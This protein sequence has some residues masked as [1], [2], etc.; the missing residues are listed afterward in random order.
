M[1]DLCVHSICVFWR[2]YSDRVNDLRDIESSNGNGT[3]KVSF[4]LDTAFWVP[5]WDKDHFNTQA[6]VG[7]FSKFEPELAFPE[8]NVEGGMLNWGLRSAEFSKNTDSRQHETQLG[9]NFETTIDGG[10]GGKAAKKSPN[11]KRVVSVVDS[12]SHWPRLWRVCISDEELKAMQKLDKKEQKKMIPSNED[13]MPKALQPRLRD[14]FTAMDT[15]REKNL[16]ASSFEGVA[17]VTY[18]ITCTHRNVFQLE[19]FPFD[20]HNL[21][22]V[23]RLDKKEGDPMARTIIPTAHDKGFFVSS[24][25]SEMVNFKLARNLDWEVTKEPMATG[26]LQR[27]NTYAIVRRNA[28]YYTRNYIIISFLLTSSVFSC[29][30]ARPE[31]MNARA[32]IVFTVVVSTIAFKAAGGSKLPQVPYGTTLDSY[33]LLSLYVVLFI[34]AVAFAFATQCSSGGIM[35]G[36]KKR[37]HVDTSCSRNP[38]RL[39]NLNWIPD[40]ES[41]H[42]SVV[43]GFL[44]ICW[45]LFNVWKWKSAIDR[46][47]HNLKVVDQVMIGWMVY[48]AKVVKGAKLSENVYERL[49]HRIEVSNGLV[50]TSRWAVCLR[51]FFTRKNKTQSPELELPALSKES[52]APAQPQLTASPAAQLVLGRS[53]SNPLTPSSD[54]SS[55]SSKGKEDDVVKEMQKAAK[56]G[57][58]TAQYNLGTLYREGRG[59]T[60]D[61]AEAAKWFKSAALKG[62][63]AAQSSLALMYQQGQGVRKNDEEA[64]RWIKKSAEQ[65]YPEGLNNL[66]VRCKHG[67]GVPQSDDLALHCF[68]LGAD[69]GHAGAMNNLG[70]M[71]KSGRGVPQSDT[72]AFRWQ[73]Q[74]AENGDADGQNNLGILY[75]QGRGVSRSDDE[76]VRWYKLAA[77]QGHALA[78]NNLA[79]KYKSGRGVKQSDEVAVECFLKAAEQ[80]HAQAQN[81]LGVMYKQGRGAKKSDKQAVFWYTRAGEQGDADAQNSLGVMFQEGKGCTQSFEEAVRWYRKAAEQGH[82]L[83][84]NN[85]AL[86]YDKGRG[87]EQSNE[88][89]VLWYKKSSGKGNANAQNN[90]GMKYKNGQG[91]TT[92]NEEAVRLFR[93]A[94]EQ[95]HPGAHNNL[96]A[97]YKEGLG[98]DHS[99]ENA[100]RWFQKAAN[101]GHA[102]AQSS[103][104][105]MYKTGR[106]V[107]KSDEQAVNWYH[108]AAE[109]GDP[110]S[111]YS[112][113]IM[114]EKGQGCPKDFEMAL[115]L[116]S[117]AGT[118]GH[119]GAQA[120]A[121]RLREAVLF[122]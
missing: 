47:R 119:S 79:L 17:F 96:G 97:M 12:G 115:K 19:E 110:V 102:G 71:Y 72:E 67:R 105:Y 100:V 21:G 64:V 38:G 62:D 33:F 83:A 27:L 106:G 35:S 20:F 122:L 45:F 109:Q 74:A 69:K 94:A 60:E 101:L 25:V 81:N 55:R 104:A 116:Y 9:Q 113:G 36:N 54:T 41:V 87:V 37:V 58:T 86:K 50:K 29:F 84:Q 121:A 1:F 10:K 16:S 6:T 108:K 48:K 112:L 66:G 103:L 3:F 23:V 14:L 99:D 13:P 11:Q 65:E 8:V 63:A 57:D 111:Q 107:A 56:K 85:L 24:R 46:V 39:Y 90:L 28:D 92:S 42:E 75:H 78:L 53:E 93:T 59:V 49:I 34:G 88:L 15:Q 117:R 26:G 2:L 22:I 5:W 7:T 120:N 18:E 118:Q 31:D 89:A 61:D 52:I 30:A 73:K 44:F 40:Y 98:V 70:A 80:G 43:A 114:C 51:F 32:T 82:V 95:G 76:A 68:R 4:F 91:V 77:E